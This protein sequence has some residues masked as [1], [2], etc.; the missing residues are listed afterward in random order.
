MNKM[1]RD[2]RTDHHNILRVLRLMKRSL[3]NFDGKLDSEKFERVRECIKYLCEY[4]DRVHH[5]REDMMFEMLL[6]REPKVEDQV[7]NLHQEHIDLFIRSRQLLDSLESA[8]SGKSDTIDALHQQAHEYSNMQISHMRHEELAVF[9]LIEHK[10]TLNDWKAIIAQAPSDK[11][12]VFSEKP[13]KKGSSG[14]L[15]LKKYF[16]SER[17]S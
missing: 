10:L 17:I 6:N 9:P 4:P 8:E 7:G 12:P 14:Y 5:P 3:S 13:L 16:Y 2:L 1:I 15:L 11:D